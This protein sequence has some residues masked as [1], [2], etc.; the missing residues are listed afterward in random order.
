MKNQTRIFAI[1]LLLLLCTVS[2][3][4]STSPVGTATSTIIPQPAVTKTSTQTLTQIDLYAS[5]GAFLLIET[6]P[7]VYH[8]M[9]IRTGAITPFNLP[10]SNEQYDLADS[11]SPSGT[12]IFLPINPEEVQIVDLITGDKRTAL[13]R[14]PIQFQ[15]EQAVDSALESLPELAYSSETM[16]LALQTAYDDS[17]QNIQWY[18]DDDHLIWTMAGSEISTNLFLL[19]VET[20]EQVQLD[21]LPGLVQSAHVSPDGKT[22]LLKKG[23][24]VEPGIW[25]DDR[26]YLVTIDTKAAIPISLPEAVENPSLSWLTSQSIGIIH[27]TALIGGENYSII[28]ASSLQATPIVH[29]VFTS[30]HQFSGSFL[31]INQHQ[32]E[33]T[34]SLALIDTTGQQLHTI[35]LDQLC[36]LK[37][38]VNQ[39]II[40]NCAAESQLLDSTLQMSGFNDPVSLLISA[41]DSAASV[42][43]TRTDFILLLN[44]NLEIHQPLSLSGTPLEIRWLPDSSGFL[45][46]TRGALYCYNLT[47]DEDRLLLTSNFF[48]DYT[49]LNA[50]W[51]NTP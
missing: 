41:P 21:N 7:Y 38:V 40:L 22:I 14:N 32:E 34:T 17:I 44:S 25:E 15:P 10:E 39:K 35:V 33:N 46:R 13:E 50:V 1:I 9:D 27:Q 47:S 8:V 36:S 49:N 2:C 6:D 29:G 28:D 23:F 26:Y 4:S 19:N 42:L 3:G 20:G 43:V 18:Q 11:L 30:I 51:I 45:Y 37:A 24:V 48:S 16:H 12:Q 31:V 5:D